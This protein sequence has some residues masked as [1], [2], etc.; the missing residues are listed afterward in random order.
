MANKPYVVDF[1]NQTK[2]VRMVKK[3]SL[4]Q[5]VLLRT[6]LEYLE[7]AGTANLTTGEWTKSLG[8][9]IFE[10]RLGPSTTTV[11]NKIRGTIST[12]YPHEKMLLRIY[13]VQ[14]KAF[15]FLVLS[16]YNK[17]ADTSKS[18]QQ[19]EISTARKIYLAWRSSN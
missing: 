3:L 13:M 18:R 2:F 7:T 17:L 6:F 5:Q 9:G 12:T 8:Q 11:A 1:A 14:P 16:G 10:L 15:L 4:T 19:H